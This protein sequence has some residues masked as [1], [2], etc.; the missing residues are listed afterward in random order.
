MCNRVGSWMQSGIMRM[1]RMR[2]DLTIKYAGPVV[3]CTSRLGCSGVK[4]GWKKRGKIFTCIEFVRP[5]KGLA[6][7][8]NSVLWSS[9]P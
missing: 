9:R 2:T 3:K 1:R 5:L 6:S 4:L 8:K 7:V